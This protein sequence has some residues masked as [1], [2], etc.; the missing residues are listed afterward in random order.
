MLLFGKLSKPHEPARQ[1]KSIKLLILLSLRAI[2]FRSYHYETPCI[3]KN[4][5]G[6]GMHFEINNFIGIYFKFI[7]FWFH[8]YKTP[9][10]LSYILLP[11]QGLYLQHWQLEGHVRQCFQIHQFLQSK[12]RWSHVLEHHLKRE[13]FIKSQK[14]GYWMYWS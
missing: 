13:F 14:D 5:V 11:N 3:L 12:H 7:L 6:N 9:I 1:H 8:S 4:K 10:S 2:Y